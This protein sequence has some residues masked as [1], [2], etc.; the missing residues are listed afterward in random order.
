MEVLRWL[1]S[2]CRGWDWRESAWEGA[3][4]GGHLEVSWWLIECVGPPDGI[5][6]SCALCAAAHSGHV[7]ALETLLGHW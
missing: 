2:E 3:A 1:Q 4:A 5:D 7:V 6:L